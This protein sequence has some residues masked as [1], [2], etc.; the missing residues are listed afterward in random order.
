VLPRSVQ[1][2]QHCILSKFHFVA[3]FIFF[4]MLAPSRDRMK[5][6]GVELKGF[7]YGVTGQPWPENGP[8]HIA[9]FDFGC[10]LN[11]C[12][13]PLKQYV[14]VYIYIYIYIYIIYIYMCVGLFFKCPWHFQLSEVYLLLGL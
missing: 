3:M 12:C 5:L 13:L 8:D 10:Q 2:S 14:Y 6:A 9:V 11:L 4:K 7:V 1:S